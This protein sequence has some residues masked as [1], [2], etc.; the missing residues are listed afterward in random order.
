VQ[1]QAGALFVCAVQK[2]IPRSHENNNINKIITA[3]A[4]TMHFSNYIINLRLVKLR[5]TVLPASYML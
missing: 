5:T 4:V 3:I 2:I 1:P